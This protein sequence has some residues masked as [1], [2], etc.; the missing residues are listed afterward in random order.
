MK[1]QYT[2]LND[3]NTIYFDFS[4]QLKSAIMMKTL[5]VCKYHGGPLLGES[6][7]N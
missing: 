6:Y 7:A 2:Q 4:K 3:V 5:A 1:N